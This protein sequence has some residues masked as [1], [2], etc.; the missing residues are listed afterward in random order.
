VRHGRITK[1][2][3][4]LLRWG[5][6]EAAQAAIKKSLYLR[7]YYERIKRRAGANSATVATARRILE[8]IYSIWNN[9]RQYYEVGR[10]KSL[11]V[12]L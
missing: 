8:I 2:G 9:K 4:S 12:A 7:G 5:L 1:Q 6:T 10:N 11:A 3:N